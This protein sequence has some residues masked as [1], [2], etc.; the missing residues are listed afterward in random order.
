MLQ[1]ENVTANVGLEPRPLLAGST[2]QLQAYYSQR[3]QGKHVL[4]RLP[5]LE[6]SAVNRSVALEH[7]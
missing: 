2:N 1:A 3:F 4:L 7:K 5:V 6:V